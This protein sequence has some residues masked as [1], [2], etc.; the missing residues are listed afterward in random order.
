LVIDV[1]PHLNLFCSALLAG[2]EHQLNGQ[3]ESHSYTDLQY[4]F[5][6]LKKSLCKQNWNEVHPIMDMAFSL[7]IIKLPDYIPGLAH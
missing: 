1:P 5:S 2:K 4:T 3:S 6:V 7:S